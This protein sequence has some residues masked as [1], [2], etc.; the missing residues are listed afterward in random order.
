M[1]KQQSKKGQ[2]PRSAISREFTHII[3]ILEKK[4]TSASDEFKI[5]L[6]LILG[7]NKLQVAFL[8]LLMNANCK[9]IIYRSW[10]SRRGFCF[11]FRRRLFNDLKPPANFNAFS[12]R[13]WFR[14]FWT[15]LN[16]IWISCEQQ[17]T[18]KYTIINYSKHFEHLM[19][20]F[21]SNFFNSKLIN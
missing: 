5:L 8:F 6:L 21:R 15:R 20:T 3:R 4:I 16:L 9:I 11:V 10:L 18:I 19:I 1:K 14:T 13:S 17:Q 12:W 2:R 7:R